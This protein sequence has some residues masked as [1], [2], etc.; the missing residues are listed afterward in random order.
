MRSMDMT[1]QMRISVQGR[2]D[3]QLGINASLAAGRSDF[4]MLRLFPSLDSYRCM[5]PGYIAKPPKAGL[6][7][8]SQ[9]LLM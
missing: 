6:L 7:L 9:I 5:R 2:M 8:L 3:R 4:L 1:R